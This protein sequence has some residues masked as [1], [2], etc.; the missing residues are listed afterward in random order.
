[1]TVTGV[2]DNPVL[3]GSGGTLAYT[4]NGSPAV[5]PGLNVSDVDSPNLT[6]ATVQ[7]T[8][9]Y[10]SSEDEL[11][12]SDQNSIVGVFSQATGTLTLSGSSSVANYQ[13][14]LRSVQYSNS[15]EDPNTTTRTVTFQ[16]DDGAAANNLSNTVTR[17]ISITRVNDA[18]VA[19]DDSF[20][21]ALG[22]TRF[23]VGTSATGPHITISGTALTGDSDP[24]TPT[25]NLTVTAT[26]TTSA[27]CTA[28]CANNVQINADGSFVYDP[29]PGYTGNDTF[30]YTVQD[31][32]TGDA[33]SPAQTD[34][35]QVTITVA[36]PVIWYVDGDA[37]AGGD[38]RS[39][40]PF[41]TLAPLT[42]GGSSDAKDG[43]GDR[44]FLYDAIA[45]A[46]TGGIVLETNQQ[47]IGEPQGLSATPDDVDHAQ[48][49][50]PPPATTR[51]CRTRPL[52]R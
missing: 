52:T 1:M 36:A 18:P 5:D 38:G 46:Y 21:G 9:N 34:T 3:S 15:S 6:G 42:T 23:S 33:P 20:A 27:N 37:A 40:S 28:P 45:G 43:S 48:P 17:D 41:N 8:G 2:N 47:L 25:G 22:N 19:G 24:D 11:E 51:S 50:F 30:N 26:T 12:F 35:G 14:A 39:H 4:E 49:R 16:V 29:P 32:D 44:I 13:T 7:I 31:N 10:Q